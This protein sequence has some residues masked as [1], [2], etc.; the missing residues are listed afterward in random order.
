MTGLTDKDL[1]LRS[2]RRAETHRVLGTGVGN[3]LVREL[4]DVAHLISLLSAT[5]QAGDD[6]DTALLWNRL[7]AAWQKAKSLLDEIQR[8]R[9]RTAEEASR[10]AALEDSRQQQG[11]PVHLAAANTEQIIAIAEA[12]VWRQLALQAMDEAW[13][14]G[15]TAAER[16]A[17]AEVLEMERR[18]AGCIL[19]LTPK[20][21]HHQ[22]KGE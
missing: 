17:V 18:L 6:A 10:R 13:D 16:E 19:P 5:K 9:D 2:L 21:M 7:P 20:S 12:A 22:S 1:Q 8:H 4:T 15:D 3:D 11:L 14:Q